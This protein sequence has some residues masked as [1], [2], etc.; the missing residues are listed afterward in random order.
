M[1][2]PPAIIHAVETGPEEA[3]LVVLIHGSLDRSGGMAPVAR[4][5]QARFRVLRYDRRGYGRSSPHG[6][7]FGIEDQVDDL[8][9]L[10][11]GRRAVLVG[12]SFGGHIAVAASV[13]LGEQVAG[14]SLYE[15]PVSWMP[16]W[17]PTTA[18]SHAVRVSPQDAAETF[19]RRLIG[20]TGWDGL[21]ERS[22]AARRREGVALHGELSSLVGT[23][24]WEP[25]AV[26]TSLICGRGTLGPEH[27]RTG[28]AWIASAVP[29]AREVVIDGAGHAAPVS[30]P[31]EYA[32][33]L[34]EPHLAA[35]T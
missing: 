10:L 12:H 16:W 26:R 14:V 13:R 24:P 20:D 25:A 28:T 9:A 3:P 11:K 22:R 29:G 2:T 33:L 34:V 7:P 8:V 30:H 18:G 17:P 19:M 15:S 32:A 27:H 4:V 6:G 5:I 23:P 1:G 21:P 31:Q 35:F